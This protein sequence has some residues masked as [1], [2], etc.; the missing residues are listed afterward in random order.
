MQYSEGNWQTPQGHGPLLCIT[1]MA[2]RTHAI[3]APPP[4]VTP[5]FRRV[6]H[7]IRSEDTGVALRGAPGARAAGT[8]MTRTKCFPTSP[9][10]PACDPT[11]TVIC[12]GGA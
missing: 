6:A 1:N 2:F 9:G 7:V 3:G 11:L 5:K 4:A 10:G 12:N 8:S